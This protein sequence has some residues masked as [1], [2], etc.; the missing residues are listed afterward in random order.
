MRSSRR[1]LGLAAWLIGVCV[2]AAQAPFDVARLMAMFAQVDRSSVAFEET[3]HFAALTTP[4][5]RRGTLRFER[6]D[7]LEMNVVSP[8]PETVRVAGSRI[9]IESPD[10]RREW[11][12]SAQPGALAWIEAI[13][14][15]LAG[16]AAALAR[17]FDASLTGAEAMWELK[18]VPRDERVVGAMRQMT[19]RGRE[20]QVASIEI[21]D[22]RGDRVVIA[23]KPLE[24]T[25]P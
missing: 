8:F 2:F 17:S 18:L 5:I 12:L 11:D 16:D 3:R 25:R 19:V 7:R 21:V 20:A 22:R 9:S 24:R 6:P 15:S 14:A 4:V 23:L 13:R 1:L 10:G